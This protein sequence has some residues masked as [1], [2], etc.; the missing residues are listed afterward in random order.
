[1]PFVYRINGEA[2]T[3]DE[4]E[5]WSAG[6][7]RRMGYETPRDSVEDMVAD[8]SAPGGHGTHWSG[9]SFVSEALGCH[10]SQC[11]EY[12]EQLR[13]RGITGVEVLASGAVKIADPAA[14]QRLI[15]EKGMGDFNSAGSG[16]MKGTSHTEVQER[17]RRNREAEAEQKKSIRKKATKIA[18]Q[19]N[20]RLGKRA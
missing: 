5:E 14:R 13:E 4:Y 1:M 16:E 9:G 7:M 19:F 2:V 8:R 6:R 18:D 20:E 15:D 10:P 12:A 3:K 17:E 11:R